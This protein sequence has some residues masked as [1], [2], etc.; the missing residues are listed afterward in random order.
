MDSLIELAI[1]VGRLEQ[2]IK[3]LEERNQAAAMNVSPVFGPEE[4][5]DEEKKTAD[6]RIQEGIDN[7]MGYQWPPA[8]EE[9]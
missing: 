4:E 2:R 5:E 6:K 3:Q 1:A 9:G 8:K 7:I